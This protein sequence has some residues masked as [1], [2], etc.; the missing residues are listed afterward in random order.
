VGFGHTISLD[1][2]SVSEEPV[3]RNEGTARSVPE[4]SSLPTPNNAPPLRPSTAHDR[5]TGWAGGGWEPAFAE[6]EGAGEGEPG[7][8]HKGN[9]R[10]KPQ[11]GEQ[12]DH[13]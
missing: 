6:D 1:I 8:D 5:A 3:L 11:S 13:R 10:V 9:Q 2:L 7:T 12:S 4:A